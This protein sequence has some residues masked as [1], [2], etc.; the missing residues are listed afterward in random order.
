MHIEHCILTIGLV[1]SI[2]H[3]LIK[4]R[5]PVISIGRT[6]IAVRINLTAI[7]IIFPSCPLGEIHLSVIYDKL[8]RAGFC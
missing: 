6:L 4:R 2:G 5:S 1:Q 7:Q 3:D 8:Y